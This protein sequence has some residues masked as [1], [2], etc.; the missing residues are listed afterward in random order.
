MSPR[1][2]LWHKGLS[3]LAMR[4][5]LETAYMNR[6]PEQVIVPI[7]CTAV[8]PSYGPAAV[9]EAQKNGPKG[10]VK[11]ECDSGDGV[12]GRKRTGAAPLK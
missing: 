4:N 12:S 11:V 9:K 5:E 7:H 10:R 8:G 6:L 3:A 2:S 1:P